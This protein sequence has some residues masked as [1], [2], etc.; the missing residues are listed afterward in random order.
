MIAQLLQMVQFSVQSPKQGAQ[1]VLD[2]KP[3]REI[4]WL[5]LALVVALSVILAQLMTY[6]VPV[7]N[8][9]GTLMPFQSSPVMFALIMWGLLVLM[10]FCTHYIG[11]MFG[12]TGEFDDSL[13][14]VIWLQTILLVIQAAQLVIALVSPSISGIIGLLFGLFSIWI[15]INFVAVVHAFQS[16]TYVFIG[17]I[18]SV[19]GVV[20]G[21]SMLFVFI[22][23]LFGLDLQNA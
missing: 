11:A 14:I 1:M 17:L 22:S 9:N 6:M 21:L 13:T 23:I 4:L 19:F 16:L 10:V 3:A 2:A 15:F 5:M 8:D 20:F 7:P 12:G 18:L